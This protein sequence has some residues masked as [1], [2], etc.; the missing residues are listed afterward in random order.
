MPQHALTQQPLVLK[1]VVVI[2][3]DAAWIA[4]HTALY[5]NPLY[6]LTDPQIEAITNEMYWSTGFESSV[7]RVPLDDLLAQKVPLS[8]RQRMQFMAGGPIWR[9]PAM[10]VTDV[11]RGNR[12]DHA[13]V[14]LRYAV[15]IQA[16]I[17][18]A[19]IKGA[20]EK[21]YSRYQNR[22]PQGQWHTEA[23]THASEFMEHA[24]GQPSILNLEGESICIRNE[25]ISRTLQ[26][27]TVGKFTAIAC[28]KFE[29]AQTTARDFIDKPKTKGAF[30]PTYRHERPHIY[31]SNMDRIADEMAN[32][33]AAFDFE[34]D[35]IALGAWYQRIVT[36]LRLGASAFEEMDEARKHVA[37]EMVKVNLEYQRLLRQDAAPNVTRKI[38]ELRARVSELA[39]GFDLKIEN[40]LVQVDSERKDFGI[41]RSIAPLDAAIIAFF[42]SVNAR[43]VIP[44]ICSELPEAFGDVLES[45]VWLGHLHRRRLSDMDAHNARAFLNALQ[46][47]NGKTE[48]HLAVQGCLE[49]GLSFLSDADR[50]DLASSAEEIVSTGEPRTV[51][52]SLQ[53]FTAEA[54]CDAMAVA[55]VVEDAP[56][57][58]DIAQHAQ[59]KEPDDE[60][61]NYYRY[62][63]ELGAYQ[64]MFPEL[65]LRST[66][67][68]LPPFYQANWAGRWRVKRDEDKYF[69]GVVPV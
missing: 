67:I 65:H 38:E 12:K 50:A 8:G 27:G 26:D 19:V 66:F 46:Q 22:K 13:G 62:N 4:D 18:K 1:D 54:E 44:A 3:H 56:A 15:A 60:P 40:A 21:Q 55:P 69:I 37:E 58:A 23:E 59:E 48:Q 20:F 31:R 33:T 47:A 49:V 25:I 6:D 35:G 28:P 63:P 68:S 30:G 57:L 5:I 17:G 24:L 42:G 2:L 9:L 52:L 10:F 36:A 53:Q 34:L 43:S 32:S 64:S 7:L 45:L 16:V 41:F 11:R 51:I 29:A 39:D 14:T 61:A